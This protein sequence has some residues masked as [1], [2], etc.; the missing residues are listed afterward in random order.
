MS[1]R[2]FT[3]SS[4]P[5]WP[6]FQ[7][8]IVADD[9]SCQD[10]IHIGTKLKRYLLKPSAVIPI[11]DY[12][13]SRG[14]LVELINTSSKDQHGL[15]ESHINPKDKM[16]FRAAQIMSD[17][18]VT[19]LLR[20]TVP[21]SEATATFLDMM[22]EVVEAFIDPTLKPLQ[23]IEKI[24]KWTFFLR[25]W[26]SWIEQHKDYLLTYNFIT[27][28]CY[29]CIEI[30]AH[31]LIQF[32][33][34]MRDS[35]KPHLFLPWLLG[36]Q[37]CEE[38]F[39]RLRS[40]A[41]SHCGVTS[42]SIM[43]IE[44]NFRRLELLCDTYANLQKVFTFPRRNRA[45]KE[46]KGIPFIPVTLPENYEIEQSISIAL[47]SAIQIARKFGII[48]K[49]VPKNFVPLCQV[50][51]TSNFA[52]DQ[53]DDEEYQQDDDDDL[54]IDASGTENGEDGGDDSDTGCRPEDFIDDVNDVV[55][56]LFVVS[57]GALGVK[58][59]QN[60]VVTETSPF[61]RV[62][63]GNGHESIIR[64][65]SLCWMLSKGDT[66]LSADR[67]IRVS[68]KL[69]SHTNTG[70]PAPTIS[71]SVEEKVFLGDW[72]A[73]I[74]KGSVVVGRVLAF[75]YLSGSTVKNQEYSLLS[76]PTKP[77][78]KNAR[79]LGALCTWFSIKGRTLHPLQMDMHGYYSLE[80]Y[81]CT[82]PR[83]S[84]NNNSLT[85]SCS[86]ASIKNRMLPKM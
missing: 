34:K 5:R 39:R 12:L 20:T 32:L 21:K 17:A 1:A 53:E 55:E 16:N 13:V 77:P 8:K 10:S 60:A 80:F 56:D 25:M 7:A 28:N 47:E 9:S 24:W 33:V 4:P 74:E 75:S 82:L 27:L 58:T 49:S 52:M 23:R 44:N 57:S 72:C 50:K 41:G 78:E 70:G 36:S 85:L 51:L 38:K 22:R 30:N 43:D 35:E 2:T 62:K 67:L 26:R 68:S 64:K 6:W 79:G 18:K 3:S 42:F 19:Q 40:Y 86:V 71:P 46:S 45:P 63:D 66:K 59:F 31:G 29:I 65:S 73:F 61:V 69:V 76:A 81:I 84:Y 15:T 83:P 11:G 48:P 37:P 14:H 54:E